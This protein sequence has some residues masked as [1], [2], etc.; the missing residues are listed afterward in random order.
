MIYILMHGKTWHVIGLL[1]NKFFHSPHIQQ[2]SFDHI[3]SFPF[4]IQPLSAPFSGYV[5]ELLLKFLI[6]TIFQKIV[7]TGDSLRF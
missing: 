7:W 2:E 1:K 6:W 4:H 3:V 5:G